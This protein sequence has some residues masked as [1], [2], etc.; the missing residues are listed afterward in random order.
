MVILFI[1]AGGYSKISQEL[2]HQLP[3][4]EFTYFATYELPERE[5][6]YSKRSGYEYFLQIE[7]N[8][9]Y[10]LDYVNVRTKR[11]IEFDGS[12]WHSN[13]E[14]DAIRELNIIDQG[15]QFLRVLDTEYSKD[16]KGVI[17][18]CQKFLQ[19]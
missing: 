2:F 15:F 16:K 8:K 4:D 10:F 13:P 1:C 12:Y 19:S 5:V 7:D 11:V 14:K 6:K 18:K 3:N 9:V 17:L